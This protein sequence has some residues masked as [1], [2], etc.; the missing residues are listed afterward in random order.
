MPPGTGDIQITLGQEVRLD[1]AVIVTTP[2][3]ISYVDVIKGIEMFDDLKVPTISIVENMAFYNCSHCN[4]KEF[5][6][7]KGKIEQLKTQ[8]GIKNSFELP[9]LRDVSAYSDKGL[10]PVIVFPEEHIYSAT[11]KNIAN[12]VDSEI[13]SLKKTNQEVVFHY[14]TSKR[15]LV[16]KK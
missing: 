13:T 16:I 14:N 2:Q 10:P 5:I 15:Q 6:F 12:S 3:D 4:E 8:F 7:G 1:G 11:F 9:L